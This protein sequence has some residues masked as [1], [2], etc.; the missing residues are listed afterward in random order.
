MQ[1]LR[2]PLLHLESA[3]HSAAHSTAHSA[4]HLLSSVTSVAAFMAVALL[5]I[6]LVHGH[7]VRSWH[8]D[9]MAL[10][11]DDRLTGEGLLAVQSRVS[12]KKSLTHL[13]LLEDSG[14][15]SVDGEGWWDHVTRRLRRRGQRLTGQGV[16]VGREQ[17]R[18]CGFQRSCSSR[19][20]FS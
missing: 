18:S 4:A 13:E 5:R 8:W 3:S 14:A 11:V 2:N 17:R 19:R 12:T 7:R 6:R 1:G 10:L 9:R 16:E 20:V 15:T